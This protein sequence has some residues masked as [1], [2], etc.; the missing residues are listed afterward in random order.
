MD[1]LNAEYSQRHNFDTINNK[2]NCHHETAVLALFHK[3]IR[4]EDAGP[5]QVGVLNLPQTV[6]PSKAL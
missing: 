2:D 4:H 6:S 5:S 3:P 1:F